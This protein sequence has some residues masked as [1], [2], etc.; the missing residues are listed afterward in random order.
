MSTASA[1]A[2]PGQLRPEELVER[3]APL[4]KRIGNHL[5]GRLHPVPLGF[6]KQ[7]QITEIGVGHKQPF[8]GRPRLE[9]RD[10]RAKRYGGKGVA[11]ALGVFLGLALGALDDTV[12]EEGVKLD[13][14][15]QVGHNVHIGAHTAIAGCVA[16]AG[17][18]TIGR[19]CM[20]GGLS[21]I[22]GHIEILGFAEGT[23]FL[24][25][26][27]TSDGFEAELGLDE[28]HP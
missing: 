10:T 21:A 18:V 26:E 13:N 6:F 25:L 16:V 9:L 20:I 28:V 22:S 2:L 11:T 8:G 5:L 23:G 19:N 4:V 14:Q 3:Y 17:S 1:Y 27:I 24:R 12:I 7:A 15:I